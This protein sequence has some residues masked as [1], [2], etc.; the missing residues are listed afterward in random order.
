MIV[1]SAEL[2]KNDAVDPECGS[3]LATLLEKGVRVN[4]FIITSFLITMRHIT[5]V[6]K[7]STD[8]KP[9]KL[10][11]VVVRVKELN[12]LRGQTAVSLDQNGGPLL[13]FLPNVI[14]N[15]DENSKISFSNGQLLIDGKAYDGDI[16][17]SQG[18]PE[19]QPD[20]DGY[21]LAVKMVQKE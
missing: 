8:S 5:D 13:M 2:D 11:P 19:G 7:H 3:H 10:R 16:Y 15:I 9:K 4:I 6:L 12:A 21:H 17:F 1:A 18:N 20:I 14:S